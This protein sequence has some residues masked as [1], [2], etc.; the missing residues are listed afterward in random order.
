MIIPH[1]A[2]PVTLQTFADQ[3][4]FALQS[5]E[6]GEPYVLLY[7]NG[8]DKIVVGTFKTVEAALFIRSLDIEL[9][10]DRQPNLYL[11]KGGVEVNGMSL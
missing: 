4:A 6:D 2:L 1:D 10:P 3:D 11:V 7:G 8:E 5:A 9:S